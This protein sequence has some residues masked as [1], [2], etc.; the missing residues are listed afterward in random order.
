M[1]HVAILIAS[2]SM[3]VSVV[4]LTWQLTLYHLSGARIRVTVAPALMTHMGHVLSGLN[5]K[6]PERQQTIPKVGDLWVELAQ[7]GVANVGRTVVWV[8]SIGLDFGRAS[9]IRP[10]QR[11][12]MSLRPLAVFGGLADNTSTRLEPG[13]DVVMYVPIIEGVEWARKELG[14][15]HLRVR[16]SATLSGRRS[17]LS[18]WLRAWRIDH[19]RSARYPHSEITQEVR[20]F[21]TLINAWPTSDCGQVYEAWLDVWNALTGQSD[22]DNLAEALMPYFTS[23]LQRFQLATT[24]VSIYS[25][26]PPTG[27]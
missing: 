27:A 22:H 7:V 19:D 10:S 1:S 11:V 25:S 12:R 8:S 3:A 18:P 16:G 5:G 2:L 17:K 6:W 21:Q 14:R 23:P 26:S 4:G 13:Q 9:P 24:L 20:I 15:R